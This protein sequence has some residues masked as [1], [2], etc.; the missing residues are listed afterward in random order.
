MFFYFSDLIFQFIFSLK[1][2]TGINTPHRMPPSLIFKNHVLSFL[3]FCFGMYEIVHSVARTFYAIVGIGYILLRMLWLFHSYT[4][5][6][7]ME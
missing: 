4:I 5:F 3:F 2:N 6:K 1:R 7:S